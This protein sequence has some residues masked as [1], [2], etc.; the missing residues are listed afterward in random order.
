MAKRIK[1]CKIVQSQLSL[2]QKIMCA[3]YNNYYYNITTHP[4]ERIT[5]LQ[6]TQKR[7]W[8]VTCSWG[9]AGWEGL[10]PLS[11]PCTPG[12]RPP[13]DS[14]L[15]VLL[16]LQI[17]CNVAIFFPTSPS[18]H[19]LGYPGSHPH[20]PRRLFAPITPGSRPPAPPAPPP[21]TRVPTHH[22]ACTESWRP[23]AKVN[24]EQV[25]D[26]DFQSNDSNHADHKVLTRYIFSSLISFYF[27]FVYL[28]FFLYPNF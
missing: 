5:I 19:L 28:L 12:S 3:I 14:C 22:I 13:Y 27:L 8:G 9:M 7:E 11:I 2:S 1:W 18:S 25:T 20:F 17:F 24:F 6:L 21:P 15:C 4:E 26:P 23:P 10:H 16:L